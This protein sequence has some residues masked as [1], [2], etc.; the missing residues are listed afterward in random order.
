MSNQFPG[1]GGF[2]SLFEQIDSYRK[3]QTTY[4]FWR[5][6][7]FQVTISRVWFDMAL[8]PG[9]PP[10]IYY[11][12]TPLVGTQL[13]KTLDGGINHG[14]TVNPSSK[15]ISRFLVM[16]SS[17]TGLPMPFIL[18]DYL[19]YYP[20]IDQSTNDVQN[21]DN[22]ASLS[23]YTD[24]KGVQVMVVN[25]NANVGNLP[26]FQ[27]TYTNS[28]GVSRT[29]PVAT[30]QSTTVSGAIPV[31]Q[32]GATATAIPFMPL[33]S[34]DSGVRSIQSV[35]MV[36]GTD[37]GLMCFVLVKPLLTG[38]VLEQT[39]PFEVNTQDNISSMPEISDS[40]CLNILCLPSGSL[41]GV[42]FHGEIET[43]FNY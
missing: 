4:S 14:H 35:Q 5:K 6:Q 23:R 7:P 13:S 34:G 26:T 27:M 18:C 9:N 42:G 31:S 3:G 30:L 29:S 20:F 15:Y 2:D 24:G 8:A 43:I 32:T 38:V 39:A 17:A 22:S 12:S 37:V 41:S 25:T 1:S 21:L 40:A 36:S 33:A 28:T 11:A 19:F 10:P 16:S